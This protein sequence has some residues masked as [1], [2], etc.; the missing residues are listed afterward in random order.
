ML[1]NIILILLHVLADRSSIV[2]EVW[3]SLRIGLIG[4]RFVF[5]AGMQV[6]TKYSSWVTNFTQRTIIVIL[7]ISWAA[8]ASG[9]IIEWLVNRTWGRSWNWT[10]CFNLTSNCIGVGGSP[11]S[12]EQIGIKCSFYALMSSLIVILASWAC[13]TGQ[14]TLYKIL[15]RWTVHTI[16]IVI[17]WSFNWTN[18]KCCS[19]G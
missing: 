4:I 6:S 2:N 15:T 14:F 1:L 5:N 10:C 17:E 13:L 18:V 7:L 19:F 9:T 3:S 11:I 8:F 16:N 12:V